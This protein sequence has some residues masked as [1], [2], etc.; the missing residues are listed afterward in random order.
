MYVTGS[1]NLD[2]QRDVGVRITVTG[3]VQRTDKGQVYIV[4]D[5]AVIEKPV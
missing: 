3:K 1:V 2:P 5:S 4:L